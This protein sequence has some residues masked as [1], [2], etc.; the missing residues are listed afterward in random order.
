M[1]RKSFKD[2]LN[3]YKLQIVFKSQNKL[4]NTFRFKDRIPEE[5]KSGAIYKFQ[6]GP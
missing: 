1:L 6:C 5:L 3:C 4:A 2:I